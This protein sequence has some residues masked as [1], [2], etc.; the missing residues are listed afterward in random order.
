MIVRMASRAVGGSERLW[1]TTGFSAAS[2][3]GGSPQQARRRSTAGSQ[4]LADKLVVLTC[5]DYSNQPSPPVGWDRKPYPRSAMTQ[6]GPISSCCCIAAARPRRATAPL[7]DSHTHRASRGRARTPPADDASVI[8]RDD[9]EWNR[10]VVNSLGRT[11]S[12]AGSE[13]AHRCRAATCPVRARERCLEKSHRP[14][15]LR[16]WKNRNLLPGRSR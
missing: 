8:D 16:A 6:L 12:A 4:P 7:P 9:S 5:G 11:V 1:P 14:H 2:M 3:A 15:P 13:T 10:P